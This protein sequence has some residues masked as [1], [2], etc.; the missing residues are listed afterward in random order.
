M[1]L[2]AIC[3]ALLVTACAERILTHPPDPL[4]PGPARIIDWSLRTLVS[5][6]PD[7][8]LAGQ[9]IVVG[10]ESEVDGGP[11]TRLDERMRGVIADVQPGGMVL[12]GGSFRDVDQ[13]LALIGELHDASSMPPI[14]AA[15]HEGGLVSRLT[16]TGGVPATRIPPASMV[17]RAVRALDEEGLSLAEEL[18]RVMGR[19]LRALGV[20]M[21][22]APVADVDPAGRVGA[23]GRH[24]RT[25]GDDPVHVGRT[26]A[27]VAKGLQEARVAAVVKHFPGHGGLASDSHDG[28]AVLLTSA[29][30]LRDRE[31]LAF[32]L[33]FEAQPLGVMTAHLSV[34]EATGSDLPATISP[35]VTRMVREELGYDGLIVTD[36][37]NM[38]AL[39]DI[40]PEPELVV[41]AVEAGADVLLKPL[42]PVAARDALLEARADGRISRGT[43][44]QSAFRVFSVKE[45]LGILGPQWAIDAA[46]AAG[47]RRVAIETL[48]APEHEQLVERIIDLAGGSD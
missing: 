16:S 31:L 21:N 18:G 43:L 12:F 11:L 24:G 9:L 38:R 33:A 25:F 10:V 39:A 6:L 27:A 7:R 44:E 48:G 30:E 3:T 40:A 36:A 41:R 20:T 47:D 19:E 17:G 42:D 34:P 2:A 35:E 46:S 1:V 32:A 4:V 29:E 13:T 15:D 45:K 37:L 23:I 22:F 5:A 14:V 28:Y 26:A 8:T